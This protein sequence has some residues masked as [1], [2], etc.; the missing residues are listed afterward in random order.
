MSTPAPTPGHEDLAALHAQVR[1]YESELAERDAVIA[2]RDAMIEQLQ[3]QVRLLLARRFAPSSEKMSDGQLGL[4]NEAEA[5]AEEEESE[6]APD[7]EVA[8][9]RR[10]RPKRAPLP[11]YLPR[12]DIVHRLAESER[13]CPHHAVELERFGEV[14]SE[15][16]DIIPAKV[17]VL[18]HIRAKYRCPR[19]EGHL[20]TAPMP[21]QPLPKSFAS[22]GLLSFIATAKY[23]DALPLYRQHRQLQRIG[24]QC[25]RTTLARWMVGAGEL[26]V[27]LINVLR[28][29][30]LDRPYLL[31]DE[32]T[33]QVL[34][35]PGKTAESKSQLWAQ[36][37]AGPEP[38]I[39]LFDYDPTRA[40]EVPKRLLAG[41]SGA[42]H[43]DG[44]SGYAPV[45]REQGLVH[46]A[47]WAHARRGFVEVLKSL[48][49]NPKKL[50]ANPPAKARRAL[51]ALQH[52]R[53]LYAIER[54]IRDKSPHERRAVRQA[55]S[56]PVLNKLRAWLDDTHAKILPSGKLGK[57]LGYLN[58]QWEALTRFCDDGRYGIDTNPIENAIRP[59]CLGRKN[60]L[61]CDTV[62]GA[63]ASARLYSLIECAKANGIEPYAYLRHVFTELPRAQSLADVEALLPTRL[64]PAALAHDSFQGSFPAPRQ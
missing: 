60:W 14:V 20:R 64:D 17:R 25:S 48:G 62:A 29:E 31:M 7:T 61:F 54:R 15:Q 50:P 22:P 44:Y 21:A 49:L 34:K 16:L 1:R 43:T 19:C 52:I 42:L 33:V 32:T 9:Y 5:S 28:D 46:L 13:T 40:G 45:V 23:A 2:E 56:V 41:F 35:E 47:C 11:A 53:T 58:N 18:R 37:S 59:F 4:F 36:M 63:H 30:L 39:V 3:E 38:P 8:A 51:Y 10:G 12:V 57:A 6:S 24:V 27:P 26:V 55:E